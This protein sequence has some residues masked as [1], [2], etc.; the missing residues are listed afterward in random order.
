MMSRK[1]KISDSYNDERD[2]KQRQR[3]T[4]YNLNNIFREFWVF[5]Y[6]DNGD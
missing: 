3:M 4:S 2:G 5:F 6:M 1:R